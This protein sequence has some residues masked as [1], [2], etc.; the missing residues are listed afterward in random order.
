MYLHDDMVKMQSTPCCI[1]HSM[2]E[3]RTMLPTTKRK[4]ERNRRPYNKRNNEIPQGDRDRE[5][6]KKPK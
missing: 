1:F 4:N 2:I 6:G 5:K 3:A